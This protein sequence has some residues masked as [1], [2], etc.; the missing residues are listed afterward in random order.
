MDR[1]FW[2]RM[3]LA[4]VTS[5]G[6]VRAAQAAAAAPAPPRQMENLG[7][8]VVALNQG[9]GKV[10]VSWRLLGTDPE[11]VVFNV[12][13]TTANGQPAKLNKEPL[14]KVTFFEDTS[15]KLDQPT[16]YFVRPIEK[17]QELQASKAF[18]FPANA[19][20][21]PYLSVPLQTPDGYKPNDASVADLDGDGEYEI[22]LHQAGRGKDNSQ[23]GQTDPPI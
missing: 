10:F 3:V 13:R 12:Y 16:S 19:P 2:S 11:D 23:S 17:G 5:L 4:I 20:H 9:G 14:T 1:T 8:G 22:I 7:R 21:R 6:L 18:T 15:A